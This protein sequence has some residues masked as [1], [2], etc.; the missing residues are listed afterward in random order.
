MPVTVLLSSGGGDEFIASFKTE[1]IKIFGMQDNYAK[2]V[3][4]DEV[5][6]SNPMMFAW[7][8]FVL[9]DLVTDDGRELSDEEREPGNLDR[10][11]LYSKS[12]RHPNAEEIKA[13]RREKG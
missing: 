3:L 4:N 7:A 9:G 12:W 8:K 6:S 13:S 5:L 10:L 1:W 2:F 11:I